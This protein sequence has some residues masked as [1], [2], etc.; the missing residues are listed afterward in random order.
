MVVN[1]FFSDADLLR[2]CPIRHALEP[3]HQEY[4]PR[5]ARHREERP[6]ISPTQFTRLN[7]PF[8]VRRDCSIPRFIQ[9]IK[10]ASFP[11]PG[12]RPFDE[13]ISSRPRQICLGVL[14][15]FERPAAE[16]SR[17]S[18]LHQ[19]WRRLAADFAS[20]E[21]E[22]PYILRSVKFVERREWSGGGHG[23]SSRW[24]REGSGASREAR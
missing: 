24:S 20:E 6:S 2:D 4:P 17:E 19:V 8:L 23:R 22:Q 11:M 12:P 18:F 13:Q 15:P 1:A 7:P 21:V 9:R 14:N 10:N 16:H 5:S 3:M